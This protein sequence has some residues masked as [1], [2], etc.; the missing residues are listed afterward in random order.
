MLVDAPSAIRVTAVIPAFNEAGFIGA[1]LRGLRAEC[2]GCLDEVIV[3]DDGSADE[4]ARLARE[5]GAVVI[6]NGT[7]Q[8]YGASLKRGILAARGD[9]VVTLDADG[10]HRPE[11]V[12]R[13]CAEVGDYEMVIGQR[14]SLLHSP[15]W[16][17]PGKWLLGRMASYLCRRTIPD[18]NSGLRVFRRDVVQRY[19]HICPSGFSFSTTITMAFLSRNYRVRFLPIAVK[20]RVGTSTVGM[21]TG[22]ETIILVV[23]LAALFNPLRVFIPATLFCWSAGIL[24]AL[25]YL[26][27]GRGIS[28]GALL[29]MVTA[30]LLFAL[31][32]LCDQISQLRLER[33]E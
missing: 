27:M 23:R 18:L 25:P 7:N 4:T 20:P 17:M 30:V 21:S 3:V 1:V 13:V 24:W 31:G 5:A 10:Q 6:Q 14:T 2:A 29:A 28:V 8:G 26:L 11:D 15:L 19:L 33:Y 9:Y 32:I 12:K 22:L 16:R